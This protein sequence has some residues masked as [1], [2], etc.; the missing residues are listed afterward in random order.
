[1][2]D[3]IELDLDADTCANPACTCGA[4]A[5]IELDGRLYCCGGCAIAVTVQYR[6]CCG[7]DADCGGASGEDDD[8]DERSS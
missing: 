5:R 6:C 1:M 2:T 4:P 3:L 8:D 7:H